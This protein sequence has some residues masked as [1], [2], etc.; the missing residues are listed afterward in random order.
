MK[1]PIHFI[2]DYWNRNI[3][4]PLFAS[5]V[6]FLVAL[7][8]I[9]IFDLIR[10]PWTVN[11]FWENIDSE[12]HGVFL[13]IIVIVL[14][15]NYINSLT[16]SKREKGRIEHDKLLRIA[17]YKEEIEDYRPWQI[18][19]ATWRLRGLIRRMN[20]EGETTLNLRKATLMDSNLS[21]AHLEGAKLM[22]ANLEGANL[23]MAHIKGA[24]LWEAKL[25][26]AILLEA[27]LGGANLLGVQIKLFQ[28]KY[29]YLSSE[30]TMMDGT[31]Y[32]ESWAKRIGEA[33]VPKEGEKARTSHV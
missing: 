13:D 20:K 19:E 32:D 11:T 4:K 27:F 30:T 24:N 14:I 5:I 23:S 22:S 16:D 8:G 6:V 3:T 1:N 31:K 15:Y 12:I 7:I 21:S 17:Q 26:G 10:Q 25:E 18:E 33:V 2:R 29:A 9:I 28:L